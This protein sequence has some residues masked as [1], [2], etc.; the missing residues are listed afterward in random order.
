MHLRLHGNLQACTAMCTS[1]VLSNLLAQMWYHAEE[2]RG[3]GEHLG[4][5]MTALLVPQV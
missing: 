5:V 2:A 1:V 4:H 3:C